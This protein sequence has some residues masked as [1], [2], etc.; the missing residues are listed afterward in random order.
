MLDSQVVKENSREIDTYLEVLV[1][2]FEPAGGIPDVPLSRKERGSSRAPI[3][4]YVVSLWK[5]NIHAGAINSTLEK[6]LFSS[7]GIVK[8]NGVW[9]WQLLGVCLYD[10]TAIRLWKD[11]GGTQRRRYKDM[12]LM[13]AYLMAEELDNHEPYRLKVW[14]RDEDSMAR[15]G[16]REAQRVTTLYTRQ[17][18]VE[19]L[20][21]LERQLGYRGLMAMEILSERARKRGLDWSVP[22]IRRA[23][24]VVNRLRAGLAELEAVSA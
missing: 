21:D 19:E 16:T 22:K 9:M 15:Q 5:K 14:I 4:D 12:C 2:L 13:I 20:E 11:R 10:H 7:D 1:P 23:R 17:L 8:I 24:E 18:I 6:V 3:S